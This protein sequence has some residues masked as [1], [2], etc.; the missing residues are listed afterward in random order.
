MNIAIYWISNDY[1]GV[2]LCLKNLVNHWPNK[3]CNFYLFTNKKKNKGYKR[4]KNEFKFKKVFNVEMDF[5]SQGNYFLKLIEFIF[6]PVLFYKYQKK[7]FSEIKETKI[8]FDCFIVN[9]GGYPGSWK[10]MSSILS[11]KLLK[12]S[13]VFMIIHHGAVHDNFLLRLGEKWFDRVIYKNL[14]KIIAV[15]NATRQ[16]V[17]KNRKFNKKK[18]NVIHNGIILNNHFLPKIKNTKKIVIGMLGRIEKYKGHDILIK[19]FSMLEEKK[20]NQIEIKIGG[21]YSKKEEMNYILRLIKNKGIKTNIKFLG[22]IK[23]NEVE[24]F[25]RSL[26][27]FCMLTRD[28]EGFGLTI[29]EAMNHGVPVLTTKV[30][31]VGEFTNKNLVTYINRPYPISLNK[32]LNKF[33]KNR[34]PFLKKAINAKKNINKFSVKEMNKN[35]EK[36]FKI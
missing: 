16:T 20:K 28:F 34:D 26:D 8:K 3:N 5:K 30:G 33:I 24:N 21:S 31:G 12:I 35:Y 1:G 19:A 4:F 17:I 6:F 13:K 9:N 23:E 14:T 32:N 29:L 11:A 27:I 10:S 18:F 2:D 15:S 7:T 22:H 36:V 25:Y